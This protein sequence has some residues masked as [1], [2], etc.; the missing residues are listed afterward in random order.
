[1]DEPAL[2]LEGRSPAARRRKR[3]RLELHP[4]AKL[5]L[6]TAVDLLD[7]VAVDRLTIQMVLEKSGVSYGSLYHHYADIS[8]LI[9]QAIEH[10]YSRRLKESL[11]SI[12][13]L[14]RSEDSANFRREVEALIMRSS[15]ASLRRNRLERIEVL[16]ALHGR[17]RLVERIARVQQSITDEFA[18]LLREF[19]RRGWLRGD[20]DVVTLAGFIQGALLGRVVD[21]VSERP[22]DNDL[23][24]SVVLRAL[25][26]VLFPD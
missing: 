22:V 21:D 16:G 12:R 5:L 13:L 7:T 3:E 8:D 2:T 9:E 6:D 19:Q 14:L 1:M 20:I 18:S 15:E 10:R 25:S 11:E 4:T 26:S 17:P 24:G 23:W